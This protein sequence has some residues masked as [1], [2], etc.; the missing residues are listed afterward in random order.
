MRMPSSY[1][2]IFGI[3]QHPKDALMRVINILFVILH[4][5]L[6][7]R[8]RV[9]ASRPVL[10]CPMI[11]FGKFAPKYHSSSLHEPHVLL[12]V[13]CLPVSG[14]IFAGKF[15]FSGCDSGRGRGLTHEEIEVH[16]GADRLHPAP[17]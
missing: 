13:T 4:F 7:R 10:F 16:G 14:P 6:R 17:G 2:N 12:L 3:E 9:Y 11:N 15:Q 5:F 8:C 1:V